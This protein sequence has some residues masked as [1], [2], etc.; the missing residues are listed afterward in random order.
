[1]RLY[2]SVLHCDTKLGE[3]CVD[4]WTKGT[5]KA[6][7]TSSSF[8]L[9]VWNTANFVG[10]SSKSQFFSELLWETGASEDFPLQSWESKKQ[11]TVYVN[12]PKTFKRNRHIA[13]R[14]VKKVW[15]INYHQLPVLQVLP[16]G[17]L[18]F[19]FQD[20]Y[21]MMTYNYGK[22]LDSYICFTLRS[23]ENIQQHPLTLLFTCVSRVHMCGWT[24]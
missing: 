6:I 21:V 20:N 22:F 5:G 24:D 18:L 16:G 17:R 3:E 8:Y 14:E 1:M 15:V 11:Q 19:H 23:Q 4:C 7:K 2:C 12:V 10:F 9:T 13:Q